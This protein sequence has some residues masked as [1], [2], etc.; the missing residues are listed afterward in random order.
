MLALYQAFNYGTLYLL[1]SSFPSLWEGQYGMSKGVASL[2]YLSIA[3]G[4]LIG[5]QLCGRLMD[6][7]YRRLQSRAGL[8][9]DKPGP[10]EFRIPLMIPASVITP[11]GIFLYAWAAQAKTHWI[12]PNVSVSVQAPFVFSLF[13]FFLFWLC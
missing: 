8:P 11:C 3:I 4:S 5:A 13:L 10:P 7:V 2:N 1:I 9:A 6:A 12:V